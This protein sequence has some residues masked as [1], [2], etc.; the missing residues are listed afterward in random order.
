MIMASPMP[1]TSSTATETTVMNTVIPN[2]V[3]HR[4][5]ESTVA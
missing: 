3:H 1:R 4:W 5:S 2:A